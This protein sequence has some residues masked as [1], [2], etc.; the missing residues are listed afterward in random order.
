MTAPLTLLALLALAMVVRSRRR[1]PPGW[2][3]EKP[4][5]PADLTRGRKQWVERFEAAAKPM[6]RRVT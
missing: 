3:G 5:L 2:K 4:V 1:W 6:W